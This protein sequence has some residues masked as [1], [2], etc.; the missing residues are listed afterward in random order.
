MSCRSYLDS[1]DTDCGDLGDDL[2]HVLLQKLVP[3]PVQS[4]E[5]LPKQIICKLQTSKISDVLSQCPVQW[6]T[7]DLLGHPHPVEPAEGDDQPL[8]LDGGLIKV[9]S[10]NA[11]KGSRRALHQG[12][13][14][15]R[16][17]SH[18]Q[19][20]IIHQNLL[21]SPTFQFKDFDHQCQAIQGQA[22]PANQGEMSEKLFLENMERFLQIF[23]S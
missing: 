3:I 7:Y 23:K 4:G 21:H 10:S 6:E 5:F 18:L 8:S 11:G 22:S 20:Y 9:N 12:A 14:Q 1:T 13:G 19:N 17:H 16:H 15:A 2:S